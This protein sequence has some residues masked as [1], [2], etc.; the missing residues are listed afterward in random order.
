MPA[1]Y[2]VLGGLKKRNISLNRAIRINKAVI[3]NMSTTW[4]R[5][6]V[7][8]RFLQFFSKQIDHEI[9]S[10]SLLT[11]VRDCLCIS[12]Q[13]FHSHSIPLDMYQA[14]DAMSQ[15]ITRILFKCADRNSDSPVRTQV[16][17]QCRF[18]LQVIRLISCGKLL[19]DES[20]SLRHFGVA[21]ANNVLHVQISNPPVIPAAAQTA[22]QAVRVCL[23]RIFVICM[24]LASLQPQKGSQGGTS[25]AT[26]SFRSSSNMMHS[27][28]TE[29]VYYNILQSATRLGKPRN[30]MQVP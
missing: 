20:L 25:V 3:E 23:T 18:R 5:E 4:P 24:L 28:S 2:D 1:R 9:T 8:F 26:F 21:E 27:V 15:S 29:I 14:S 17:K 12:L 19:N 11:L 22:R 6:N 16:D 7:L 13:A 30:V 10:Y